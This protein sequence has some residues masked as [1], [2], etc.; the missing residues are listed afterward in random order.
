MRKL[1]RLRL[2]TNGRFDFHFAEGKWTHAGLIAF[3]RVYIY[4]GGGRYVAKNKPAA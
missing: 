3:G 1:P 2:H 4:V